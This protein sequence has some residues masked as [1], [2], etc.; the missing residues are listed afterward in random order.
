LPEIINGS[1]WISLR[2]VFAYFGVKFHT[3]MRRVE[4][5]YRY[6]PVPAFKAGKLWS[7]KNADV[8]E[9]VRV[10]GASYEREMMKCTSTKP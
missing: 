4:Y 7:F 3:V 2:E 9:W 1:R 5:R 8:D 6:M 10:G